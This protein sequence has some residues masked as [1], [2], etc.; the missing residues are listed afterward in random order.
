M[1]KRFLVHAV[2]AALL[3]SMTPGAAGDLLGRVV[4]L[5][6]TKAKIRSPSDGDQLV[7]PLLRPAL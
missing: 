1:E 6:F 5:S 7:Q 3:A 2:S 4:G